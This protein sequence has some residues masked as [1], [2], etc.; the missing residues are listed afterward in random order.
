M[1]KNVKLLTQL[2]FL[3]LVFSNSALSAPTPIEPRIIGGHQAAQN[4]WGS[5]VRLTSGDV[6]SGSGC[7]A[8]FLGDKYVLTAAHCLVD[9]EDSDELLKPS[10]IK[11]YIGIYD[12]S[13]PTVALPVK[14]YYIHKD[15]QES[16]LRNDIAIVELKESFVWPQKVTLG[17]DPYVTTPISDLTVAGWGVTNTVLDTT[18]TTLRQ[19]SVPFVS[20]ARCQAQYGTYTIDETSF[21]AGYRAGGKDSCQGDSG[22]PIVDQSKRQV[23]IVSWGDGCAEPGKYGVYTNV[24][25]YRDWIEQHTSGISYPQFLLLNNESGLEFSIP[26]KNDGSYDLTAINVI[27]ESGVNVVRNS[28]TTGLYA[29][30][31]CSIDIRVESY[32]SSYITSTVGSPITIEAQ[33]GGEN[34]NLD[35]SIREAK[36]KQVDNRPTNTSTV[37]NSKGGG[38]GSTSLGFV[39]LSVLAFFTRRFK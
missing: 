29:G 21:C 39:L 5:I 25:K 16:P 18:A 32:L 1:K 17:S 19:V 22:G 6:K 31:E 28:C 14:A 10:D 26:I 30:R 36:Y 8:S 33:R 20:L 13:D 7:G 34:I 3:G 9:F 2:S 12:L 23:G 27:T 37:N 11:V 35:V 24:A 15:Y 4:D 38:G